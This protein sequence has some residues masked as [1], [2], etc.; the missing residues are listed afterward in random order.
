V[1]LVTVERR[2]PLADAQTAIQ[3][4]EYRPAGAADEP[5]IRIEGVAFIRRM[6]ETDIAAVV[7]TTARLAAAKTSADAQLQLH[8][9]E[10]ED[11]ATDRTKW[12]SDAEAATGVAQRFE[13]RV[14]EAADELTAVETA[15]VELGRELAGASA[16]LVGTIDAQAPPPAQPPPARP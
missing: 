8:T 4:T 13:A 6:L 3:G 16:L 15:I 14:T 11:L 7:A 2:R 1:T 9:K 5:T 10:A 12:Q